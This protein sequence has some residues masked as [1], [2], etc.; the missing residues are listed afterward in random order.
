MTATNAPAQTSTGIKVLAFVV[1]AVLAL[2]VGAVVFVILIISLNGYTGSD[3]NPIMVGYLVT[4]VVSALGGGL[5]AGLGYS[6]LRRAMPGWLAFVT[7][8]TLAMGAVVV[9]LFVGTGLLIAA[10]PAT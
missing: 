10:F 3:A 6:W 8:V 1:T 9:A 5:L 7:G 2:A 4:G